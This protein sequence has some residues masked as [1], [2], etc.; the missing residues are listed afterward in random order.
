MT[1][2]V[3]FWGASDDLVEVEGDLPGCDEHGAY[4]SGDD[5]IN[6]KFLITAEHGR[7]HV[8]A[9]YDGQWA[10]A[11][12]LVDEDDMLPGWPMRLMQQKRDDGRLHYSMRLEIDLPDDATIKKLES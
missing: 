11:P 9:I 3:A 12:A 8:Y 4:N 10:F 7:M 5:L 6:A 1:K 2:T